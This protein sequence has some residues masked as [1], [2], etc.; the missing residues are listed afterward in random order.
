MGLLM[1]LRTGLLMAV[2]TGLLMAIGY[3]FGGPNVAF[4]MFLFSLFFNFITYWYSDRIVLSWYNARIVD[5]YEA[6]RA[7][8]DSEKA[9]RKRRFTD[10]EG[11]HSSDRDAQRLRHWEKPEARGRRGYHRS[12][13]AP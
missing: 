6:P 3:V 10:A 5:E 8:R 12:P 7:V 9:C 11:R 1:W 2:L 4:L 13:Q